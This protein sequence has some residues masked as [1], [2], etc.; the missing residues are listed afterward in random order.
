[1]TNTL[2]IGE[3]IARD[4]CEMDPPAGDSIEVDPVDV[5]R[6][7]DDFASTL[8]AQIEMLRDFIETAPASTGVCCC[9]ESMEGHSSPM[10]CGHTPVDLWDHSVEQI[11]ST[12]PDQALEQFAA[13]VRDQC[14]HEGWMAASGDCEDRVR[15]AIRNIKELP[16]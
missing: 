8:S 11:L 10:S 3:K 13:K 4:L 2:T 16:K 12:T 9:G 14:A 1:M 7:I 6:R 5:A 15:A